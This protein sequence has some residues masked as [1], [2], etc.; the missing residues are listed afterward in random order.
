MQPWNELSKGSSDAGRSLLL[1]YLSPIHI[2]S[3][4]RAVRYRHIPVVASIL[5][6]AAL[7]IVILLSTGLLVLAPVSIDEARNVTLVTAFETDHFRSLVPDI[8]RVPYT[9]S[10]PVNALSDI[11]TLPVHAYIKSL[12]GAGHGI[13][14]MMDNIVFQSIDGQAFDPTLVSISVDV[15]ALVPNISCEIATATP[16]LAYDNDFHFQLDTPTCSVGAVNQTEIWAFDCGGEKCKD[17]REY[18]F[19]RVDCL[20]TDVTRKENALDNNAPKDIRW[21]MVVSNLS[22]LNLTYST[23]ASARWDRT[24]NRDDKPLNISTSSLISAVICKTGYSMERATTLQNSMNSTVVL[25]QLDMIPALFNFTGEDLGEMIYLAISGSESFRV[26]ED[27]LMSP[28]WKILSETLDE[29]KTRDRLL[30]TETL[31]RAASHAWAGIAAHL[32]REN[33]L[34]PAAIGASGTVTIA[35]NRLCVGAASLWGMIAGLILAVMLTICIMFSTLGE[36]VPRDP[37]LISTDALVIASSPQLQALLRDCGDMRTSAMAAILRNARYST[38]N[39]RLFSITALKDEQAGAQETPKAKPRDWIPLVARFPMVVATLATPIIVIIILEVLY[40]ISMAG[41]GLVDVFGVE[42]EAS[43]LSRYSV[44]LVSLVTATLF[45][46]LDFTTASLAP[47]SSLQSGTV[48]GSRGLDLHILGALPPV[49]LLR[50]VQS[51]H[52]SSFCSNVAGTIGSLLTVVASG[53]LVINREVKIEQT[54]AASLHSQWDIAWPNSS[55]SG[56]GGA[57]VMFDQFQRGSVDL[58]SRIWNGIVISE[59][60]NIMITS[61]RRFFATFEANPGD[62]Q[63]HF[64]R[65]MTCARS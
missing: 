47:Y 10:S 37:G 57:G 61:Q 18:E 6:F 45:N 4:F 12:E 11:F 9:T 25:E 23:N 46:S 7:K 29:P 35:E 20:E 33:F 41:G 30:S 55:Q 42:N 24:L 49:A 36:C 5:C 62:K 3:L 51:R 8:A 43:Y 60:A 52:A 54:V 44:A 50:S 17:G 53:L 48:S 27:T 1:D 28:L 22:P 59:I 64:F 32:V 26:P 19:T 40:Q 56:D 16:R 15:D 13:A 34:R 14:G 2:T 31:Q 38:D 39:S 65:W 63:L 21:A 58:P